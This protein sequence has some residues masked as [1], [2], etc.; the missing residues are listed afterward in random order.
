MGRR[1]TQAKHIA[2]GWTGGI[3]LAGYLYCSQPYPF[4]IVR[5]ALVVTARLLTTLL[6]YLPRQSVCC[7][8]QAGRLGDSISV[9]GQEACPGGHG[10]AGRACPAMRQGG[11]WQRNKGQE[12]EQAG[13]GGRPLEGD[14]PGSCRFFSSVSWW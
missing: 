13:S 3:Y 1:A 6:I 10:Q 9:T 8:G 11:D 4:S 12:D 5:H 7:G 2:Q 14:L